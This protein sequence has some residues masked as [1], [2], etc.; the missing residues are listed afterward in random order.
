[1][2]NKVLHRMIPF[3][4]PHKLK[5][6]KLDREETIVRIPYF[7][8]NLNHLKGLHACVLITGAEY[9]SG[10]VLLQHLSPD[11]YRL[12]M[13]DLKVDYHYQAKMD[14]T[15]KFGI[16]KTDLFQTLGAEFEETGIGSISCQIPVYDQ[17][18]NLICDVTT[19]WQIKDWQKVKTKV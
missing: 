8:K 10:L 19:N 18:N 7:R 13:K 15:A 16:T 6:S 2:L 14:S 9:C 17:Q 12:I 11:K 4:K 1:M 5:V 3:N